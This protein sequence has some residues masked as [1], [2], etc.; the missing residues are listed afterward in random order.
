MESC[1]VCGEN[2]KDTAGAIEYTFEEKKMK[3]CSLTCLRIFQQ[4][5]EIYL[6]DKEDDISIL[7]DSRA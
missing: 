3:F 7:E 2:T 6:N 1:P 5:P 4:F